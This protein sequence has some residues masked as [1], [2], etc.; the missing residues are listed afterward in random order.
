MDCLASVD[1]LISRVLGMGRESKFIF[2]CSYLI[3][4]N[5][6][7]N[8]SLVRSIFHSNCRKSLDYYA[9]GLSLCT[10]YYLQGLYCKNRSMIKLGKISVARCTEISAR[11]ALMIVSSVGTLKCFKFS[12]CIR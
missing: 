7:C 12:P 1:T 6:I 8:E 9:K 10:L 11:I 5:S 3:T 2:I 4:K